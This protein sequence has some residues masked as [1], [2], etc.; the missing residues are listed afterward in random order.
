[1]CPEWEAMFLWLAGLVRLHWVQARPDI[2]NEVFRACH[3]QCEGRCLERHREPK[4]MAQAPAIC[5]VRLSFPIGSPAPIDQLLSNSAGNKRPRRLSLSLSGFLSLS[6]SLHGSAA[7]AFSL[8]VV[9]GR[10]ASSWIYQPGHL[11]ST[12]PSPQLASGP[13]LYAS[14]FK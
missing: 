1:M 5:S 8:K 12:S 7:P 14:S 10:A 2:C 3:L 6:P 13:P 11:K 9:S 4:Q